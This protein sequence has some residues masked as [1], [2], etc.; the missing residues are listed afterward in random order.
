MKTTA[1]EAREA[2]QIED[3]RE[4]RSKQLAGSIIHCL[5][6]Y[7]PDAAIN[8]AHH[9][10][11]KL[12]YESGAYLMTDEDRAEL[13]LEPRDELGWTPSE[14]LA[15]E[16]ALEMAFKTSISPMFIRPTEDEA[17]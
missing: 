4:R 10:L 15:R 6:R 2:M 1:S 17:L 13:G 7:I 3:I 16:K 5:R 11:L 14:K 9:E 12:L 8:D